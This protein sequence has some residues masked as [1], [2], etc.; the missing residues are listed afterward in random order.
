M[1]ESVYGDK[2]ISGIPIPAVAEKRPEEVKK[3]P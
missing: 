2:A 1:F 3:A